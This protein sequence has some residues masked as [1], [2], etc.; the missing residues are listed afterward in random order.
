MRA[1]DTAVLVDAD[2]TSWLSWNKYAGEFAADTGNLD[3][4]HTHLTRDREASMSQTLRAPAS[5]S[6]PVSSP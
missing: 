2:E 3:R 1:R 5:G 6:G 4:A